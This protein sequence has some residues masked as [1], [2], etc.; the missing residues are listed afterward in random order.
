MK[1]LALRAALAAGAAL[2]LLSLAYVARYGA[3]GVPHVLRAR[4]GETVRAGCRELEEGAQ[5]CVY[6][7]VS[8]VQL[9]NEAGVRVLMASEERVGD[10]ASD[11]WCQ[12]RY[13]SASPRYFGSRHWPILDG[14]FAPQWSCLRASWSKRDAIFGPGGETDAAVKWLDSLWMVNLDYADNPHNNHLLK[15]IVWMLDAALWRQSLQLDGAQGP[16][17]FE[18]GPRHV[19]LPQSAKQFETQTGKDINRLLY[20]LVLELDPHRLYPNHT[21]EELKSP[22]PSGSPSRKS[23]RLLDAFPEL[24]RDDKL[25]FYGDYQSNPN[26]SLICTPRLTVGAKL[27]NVGH[28]RVCRTLRQR[29]WDLFGVSPPPMK[30]VGQIYY[31][32]PPKRL[33]VLQRH[34]TRGIGNLPELEQALRAEFEV[35]Y[36]VEVE[37]VTTAVLKSA[38]DQ[39]RFFSRAG[40]L[41]TPH[42]SQAMGQIWMPRHRYGEP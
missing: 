27:G 34:I 16:A 14:T 8:C 30:R 24:A 42:G 12:M 32:Q 23:V 6:E 41:L 10:V 21:R 20:S 19:F 1:G 29:S 4:R 2:A 36:G 13:Q 3:R 11:R 5:T 31:P 22:L 25:V 37:V 26:V 38:E 17:L 39:V 35:K 33:I 28:E 40:V 9:R 18:D 15:D 7:G